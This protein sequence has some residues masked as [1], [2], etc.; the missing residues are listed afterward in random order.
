MDR[1]EDITLSM[2]R[3]GVSAFER[4]DEESEEPAAMVAAVYRAM[5]AANSVALRGLDLEDD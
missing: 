5:R 4:G 3:A 2:L 1:P